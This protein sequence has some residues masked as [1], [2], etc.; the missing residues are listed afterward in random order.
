MT[1]KITLEIGQHSMLCMKCDKPKK[2]VNFEFTSNEDFCNIN[3]ECGH[4]IPIW[5]D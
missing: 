2:I 4:S 1:K 3:L 5:S